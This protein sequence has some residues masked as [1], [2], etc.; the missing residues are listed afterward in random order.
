MGRYSRVRPAGCGASRRPASRS[1]ANR[2][3]QS[4]TVVGLIESSSAIRSF[5][6]PAA[7][8][9]TIRARVAI[10]CSVLPALA[11][12][13]RAARSDGSIDNGGAGWFGMIRIVAATIRIAEHSPG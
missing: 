7:A 9:S 8:R 2:R 4:S 5:A 11:S 1:F 3:R 12:A 13:R 6:T 10:R